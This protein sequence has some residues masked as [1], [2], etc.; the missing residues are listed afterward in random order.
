MVRRK[1]EE[2]A[3]PSGEVTAQWRLVA[4]LRAPLLAEECAPQSWLNVCDP[5]PYIPI[6]VYVCLALAT[7]KQERGGAIVSVF[8]S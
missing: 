1:L 4:G 2:S 5:F 3:R 8:C 7:R 6:F